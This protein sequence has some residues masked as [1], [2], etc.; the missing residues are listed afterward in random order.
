MKR[1]V[2]STILIFALVL[3]V[4]IVSSVAAAEQEIQRGG[5]L[6]MISTTCPYP[7]G[8]PPEMKST[9]VEIH[10]PVLETLIRYD[11]WQQPTIP[12]LATKWEVLN[13]GKTVNVTLRKGVKF[14]DGTDLN[15]EAAKWNFDK[16]LEAKVGEFK[17]V[18][19]VKVIDDYNV[20]FELEKPDNAFL[21]S[22]GAARGMMISP[23]AFKKNGIE[24]ARGNPVGTGAFKFVEFKRDAYCKYTKFDDYWQKGKPYLDGMEHL[25]IKD[26]MTAQAGMTAGDGEFYGHMRAKGA[27]ELKKTG[28]F[29]TIDMM[30]SVRMLYPNGQPGS[31]FADKRVRM[32]LEYAIDK[33][34]IVD[35]HGYGYWRVANQPLADVLYG[36]NP[37]IKNRSYNP[38]KAKQLLAEAG[39][40]K[41]FKTKMILFSWVTRMETF[42]AVQQYLKDVGIDAEIEVYE[43]GPWFKSKVGGWPKDT[44]FYGLTTNFPYLSHALAQQYG[45]GKMY[46]SV[47]RPPQWRDLLEKSF[48][49]SDFNK[50]KAIIQEMMQVQHDEA[51]T[52]N[53]WQIP[54]IDVS[55]PGLHGT[56]HLLAD[57]QQWTPENAWLEK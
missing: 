19:S 6:R 44:L 22:L 37:D 51:M 43:G 57:Q 14:H 18:K 28:R 38:E 34:A 3:S 9:S 31:I 50:H 2:I 4:S 53:L 45:G 54:T 40:P 55:I 52:I 35:A 11:K 36:Y 29:K 15:A 8:Y 12:W 27:S 7:I 47:Y 20:Q 13:G 49:T 48:T 46:P 21:H 24:W 30:A 5:I 39:Y 23:T 26:K 33:E 25:F 1:V 42:T 10:R 41:G 16:S 32:A 56:G 17:L